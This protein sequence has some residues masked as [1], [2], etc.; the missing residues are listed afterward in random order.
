MGAR[1]TRPAGWLSRS[2]KHGPSWLRRAR[3]GF[4]RWRATIHRNPQASFVYKWCVGTL[5]G[6]IIAGGLVLVPL[7]GPG[8]VIVFVGIAIV[9]SE[10]EWARDLLHWGRALLH[11][12]TVWLT[13]RHWSVRLLV[14]GA[15]CAFVLAVV[16]TM[17]RLIG[18]PSW[19]P[20]WLVPG[21][22]GL[23]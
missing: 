21:W 15:T 14:A 11:R 8:W 19:V 3:L 18:L 5:G 2:H 17:L 23:D 12:W 13:R 10:F 9:A 7:P 16:W 6:L 20:E 22:L 4:F 1:D